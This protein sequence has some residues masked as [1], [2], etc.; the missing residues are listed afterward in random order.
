MAA[1]V[2][3]STRQRCSYGEKAYILQGD[4]MINIRSINLVR[5]TLFAIAAACIF[6]LFPLS[7]TALA[8]E[9]EGS[10]TA[11]HSTKDPNRI[12][13]SFSRDSS[14][15]GFNMS[16]ETYS[17]AEIKGISASQVDSASR[18]DVSFT[19]VGDAGSIVCDGMFQN[20]RG[21]GFWKFSPSEAFRSDMKARGYGPLLDEE[22]LRAAMNKLT[23]G[24]IDELR[25]VGFENVEYKELLRAAGD[26]VTILFIREM[27][28]AGFPGATLKQFSRAADNGVTA[29]FVREVRSAGFADVTLEQLSRAA[30]AKVTGA[31]ISEVKNIGF[32]G[33]T[34]D[35]ISRAA[36]ENITTAYMRDIKKVG[37]QDLTL[38]NVIRLEDEG[39][40]A[41][42]V[43]G[44][45]A[46]GFSDITASMA[47][48]LK[49]EDVDRD[50][51]RRAK[52]QGYNV[53]LAE[54]I[55]L[56]D[57]GTVK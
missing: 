32:T 3:H 29:A 2:S 26:G 8:A 7:N 37:F 36:D 23:R 5:I 57:R 19:I 20:G 12:Y 17:L 14:R 6:T 56:K 51:I 31:Y 40:T 15:G 53:S 22:L 44:I 4:L 27:K 55:K 45:R 46:E 9:I 52:A 41:A 16:G 25:S 28:E 38:P 49:D 13:F 54:M 24:Y 11:Q 42:F 50:F 43:E 48:R 33:L 39:V 21:T 35:Q 1:V 47:I 10:W 30:D 18:S 34:F